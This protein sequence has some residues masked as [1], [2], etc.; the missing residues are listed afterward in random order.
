MNRKGFFVSLTALIILLILISLVLLDQT[1]GKERADTTWDESRK[2][3]VSELVFD[4]EKSMIPTTITTTVK[5]ALV[6]VTTGTTSINPL[7]IELNDGLY[8]LAQDIQLVFTLPIETLDITATNLDITQTGPYHL[9]VTA[10][11]QYG[12]KSQ[13]DIWSN[14]VQY[15]LPISVYG[16][17]HP[18]YLTNGTITPEFWR[19]KGNLCVI[20]MIG[21]TCDPTHGICPRNDIVCDLD[22]VPPALTP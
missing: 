9:L 2:E 10:T 5:D 11:V 22:T 7:R 14:I 13:N 12:L 4:L 19:K 18:D 15:K 17:T 20:S 16:M 1:A 3:L 6:S 21:K 8:N